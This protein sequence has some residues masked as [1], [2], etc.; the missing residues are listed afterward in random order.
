[1]S[2]RFEETNKLTRRFPDAGD[3]P[4]QMKLLRW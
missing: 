4:S 2:E 1:M 3:S